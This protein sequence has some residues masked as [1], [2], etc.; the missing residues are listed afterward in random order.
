MFLRTCSLV[1]STCAWKPRVAGSR[2][3]TSCVLR[4]VLCSNRL[5]N[6][7]VFGNFAFKFRNPKHASVIICDL[8]I[9][10]IPFIKESCNF[11]WLS[12]ILSCNLRIRIL[13]DL[14]FGEETCVPKEPLFCFFPSKVKDVI[15]WTISR[16]F[17]PFFPLDWHNVD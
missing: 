12:Y 7:Y 10:K 14:R 15:L 13:V 16:T 6:I 4:W 17:S 8:S 11:Y 5:A 9:S 1:V 3:A 2:S